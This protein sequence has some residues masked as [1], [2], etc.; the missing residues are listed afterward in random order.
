MTDLQILK[1]GESFTSEELL[2]LFEANVPKMGF[3]TEGSERLFF[4]A[5]RYALDETT[6]MPFVAFEIGIRKNDY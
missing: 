6:I 5:L 2:D 4:A 1:S 3:K